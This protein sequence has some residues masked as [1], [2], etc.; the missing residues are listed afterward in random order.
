MNKKHIIFVVACVIVVITVLVVFSYLEFSGFYNDLNSMEF[1]TDYV[2]NVSMNGNF[3]YPNITMEGGLLEPTKPLTFND[4][5]T[6]NYK[7]TVTDIRSVD[8]KFMSF[9]EI[10]LSEFT[11]VHKKEWEKTVHIDGQ[12]GE[13]IEGHTKPLNLYG[14]EIKFWLN[15]K[16]GL[17]MNTSILNPECIG[18]EVYPV[19]KFSLEERNIYSNILDLERGAAVPVWYFQWMSALNDNFSWSQVI[20]RNLTLNTIGVMISKNTSKNVTVMHCS[21]DE[22][23]TRYKVDG[24][25]NVNGRKCFKVYAF[26][27]IK[28]Y[29]KCND[30][31]RNI[32][33]EIVTT[34]WAV[35]NSSGVFWIDYDKRIIV[36]AVVFE[37]KIMK[38]YK[39]ILE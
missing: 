16:E 3:L 9:I 30:I 29:G 6:Y 1:D 13:V 37:K 4:G 7:I 22:I 35:G 14:C 24:I 25:E 26:T 8:N 5:E 12:D 31:M 38:I 2:T 23:T 18:T 15:K 28:D 34:N 36:K 33:K 11:G 21:N 10:I 32:N 20:R 17:I 19:K 27:S 39:V